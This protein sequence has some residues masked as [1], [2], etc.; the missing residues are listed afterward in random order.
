MSGTKLR[1]RLFFDEGVPDSAAQAFRDAG[2]EAMLLREHMATG[3]PDPAVCA[4]A[5]VN[6]AILVACDGDMKRLARNNGV[7]RGRYA[8]LS[9]IKLSCR[10]SQAAPRVECMMS[11]IEH[12]WNAGAKYGARRL[13]IE[14]GDT[15]VRTNR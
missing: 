15:W 9:L 4:I 7:N 1:L 8:R 12:E 5:E 11:L 13:F 3:S 14:I 2:H 10:P 6:E